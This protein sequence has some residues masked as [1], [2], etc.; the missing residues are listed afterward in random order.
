[1]S[2]HPSFQAARGPHH[3][4][5]EPKD[6]TDATV[7]YGQSLTWRGIQTLRSWAIPPTSLMG[8]LHLKPPAGRHTGSRWQGPDDGGHQVG[9]G[10]EKFWCFSQPPGQVRSGSAPPAPSACP[11]FPSRQDPSSWEP[12]TSPPGASVKPP[13]HW[14]RRRTSFSFGHGGGSHAAH[15]IWATPGEAPLG[16]V[17]PA[18]LASTVGRTQKHHL[19]KPRNTLK[20]RCSHHL[21]LWRRK[22]ARR[23]ASGFPR[24]GDMGM[25]ARSVSPRNVDS[26]MCPPHPTPQSTW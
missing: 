8:G 3:S 7:G 11:C 10:K 21:Q 15:E 18:S 9:K 6:P 13:P 14:A 25:R 16:T 20:D 24:P 17:V 2:L 23:R 1:M 12:R 4:L 26:V 5:P 22:L 19:L